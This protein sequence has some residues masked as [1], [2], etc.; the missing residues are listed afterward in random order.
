MNPHV[1]GALTTLTIL[2]NGHA[3]TLQII[4]AQVELA[5]VHSAGCPVLRQQPGAWHCMQQGQLL[6]GPNSFII[7]ELGHAA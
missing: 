2:G 4:E 1:P 7:L 6:K 5:A 3:L